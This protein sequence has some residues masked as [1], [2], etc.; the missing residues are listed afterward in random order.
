MGQSNTY[1]DS[2]SEISDNAVGET[3]SAE[4]R[5]A[6]TA[7]DGSSVSSILPY[8]SSPVLP[9]RAPLIAIQNDV[10][11]IGGEEVRLGF[12]I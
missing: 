8:I 11:L 9:A 10:H 1:Y 4:M 3:A 6:E 12:S 7:Q 2:I 5:H